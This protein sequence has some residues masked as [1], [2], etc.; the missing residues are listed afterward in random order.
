MCILPAVTYMLHLATQ[1][2]CFGESHSKRQL[3]LQRMLTESFI[4]HVG[5]AVCDIHEDIFRGFFF[6][7]GG[8]GDSL[9]FCWC[10]FFEVGGGGG[11]GGNLM[12]FAE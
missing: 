9:F 5:C 3:L 2:I 1:C 12:F 7:G 4:M 10:V 6:W 8:G 11:G